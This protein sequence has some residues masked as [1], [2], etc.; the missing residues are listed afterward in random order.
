MSPVQGER[1]ASRAR[2]W[3]EPS[4]EGSA[5]AEGSRTEGGWTGANQARLL[6]GLEVLRE[7]LRAREGGTDPGSS[8]KSVLSR[9]EAVER[10]AVEAVPGEAAL[11]RLAASFR[12]TS[13]EARILLL[14]AAMELDPS[15]GSLCAEAQGDP[16][17]P[18][19]TLSL[20]LAVLP[21]PHWSALA[22]GRPL[23]LWR[24]V[25][26]GGG[27]QLVTSPLRIDERILHY[28]VGVP[29]L[30]ERLRPVL[31]PVEPPARLARSQ[32]DAVRRIALLWSRRSGSRPPVVQLS[33]PDPAACRSV[34]AAAAAEVGMGLLALQAGDVPQGAV[35]RE[36]VVRL[37][38]REAVLTRSVLLVECGEDGVEAAN[39]PARR[40]LGEVGGLAAVSS[41]HPFPL[42]QTSR[43]R[44][45]LPPLRAQ[46]Q[47]ELW[48]GLL[49]PAASRMNGA[50]ERI[51]AHFRLGVEAVQAAWTQV[52]LEDSVLPGPG[53]GDLEARLWHACRVQARPRLDDLAERIEPG[54]EWEDLVLPAPQKEILRQI[55]AGVAERPTVVERWGFGRGSRRGLGL[56]ALFAGASGTGKTMAAEVLGREL[57]L[58]V[59]RIDL[60]RVVSKY[61]GETE[62]NLA[63]VFDAAD[64]GGAILLFDEAD[65]LFG[66]RTEVKD[67]HDR[68]ANIE[69]SYLL[70]RMEA[71][72]GLA[73][74]TTNMR[75]ALDSAFLR[76]IRFVVQFP[77]PD[78]G[79]RAEI[80]RRVFPPETPTEGLDPQR[81]AR[82]DLAG[83]NI[84]N[85]ALNAAFLA[86]AAREPVRM[87]HLLRA[88]RAEYAKLE[89]P[90][91]EAEVAGWR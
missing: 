41:R 5:A 58:D 50:V 44:V 7:L 6:A 19:P 29:S 43:V 68:Y 39:E 30:D 91:T 74:L 14:A 46:E 85:I 13:F 64:V 70:Q 3:S 23:R 61:I 77:F 28:L 42:P 33:G 27:D 48:A 56:T 36:L 83:G 47:E 63:R 17:R 16:A 20:A 37:W 86:A 54:P 89:R 49:G 2:V 40:L 24:L 52:E 53:E 84:R 15:F 71:Y 45:E 66:K 78:A 90:L 34:A 60:S 21:D 82:L 1:H 62:K 31:R 26:V 22:P 81:L 79:A 67:S 11:E 88:A 57:R 4:A 32:E 73:I 12:L 55:A 9:H 59:Y 75:S 69:V 87:E 8:G 38:E 76:R 72:R 65:A 80:W 35:D 51:A 18:F 25:E 10:A